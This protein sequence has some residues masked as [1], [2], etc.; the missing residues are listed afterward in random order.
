MNN[1]KT[2]IRL[3]EESRLGISP[4]ILAGIVLLSAVLLYGVYLFV[5]GRF[6]PETNLDESVSTTA[7]DRSGAQA[8]A[9]SAPEASEATPMESDQSAQ[10]DPNAVETKAGIPPLDQSDAFVRDALAGLSDRREYANWIGMEH[11][12][13][14]MTAVIDNVSRGAI[15]ASRIQP[16]A[17][18]GKFPVIE[19]DPDVYLMDPKGYHR[20]DVYAD[21]VA[22][23]DVPT[24]KQIY[25]TLKPLFDSAYVE[26][27]YPDGNFEQVL[28]R[29]INHL[30]ATPVLSGE[31]ALV[32]PSVMYRFAD[33][34]IESLS[35]AQKQLIRMGP[36]NVRIVQSVLRKFLTQLSPTDSATADGQASG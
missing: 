13:S 30:L 17:P 23:L 11:L 29:A 27:G 21:T 15:P 12:V 24:V 19:K 7:I 4:L 5:S 8:E 36:R 10:D 9:P 20:Y 18:K 25:G 32:R 28:R 31:V 33:P 16:L 6:D 3:Q 34:Q 26:L 2:S 1:P 22:S 35:Q 14:K